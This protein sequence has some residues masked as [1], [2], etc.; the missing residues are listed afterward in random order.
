MTTKTRI[1]AVTIGV[2]VSLGLIVASTRAEG[3]SAIIQSDTQATLTCD[4]CHVPGKPLPYLGG[5]Q[6]HRNSHTEFDS[7]HHASPGPDGKPRA[8]CLDCHST[9][10]QWDT[11]FPASDP[12]ST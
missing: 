6:F 11:V 10:G 4:G 5:E 12:K 2:F 7:S 3:Q 9:N 8:A 1:R